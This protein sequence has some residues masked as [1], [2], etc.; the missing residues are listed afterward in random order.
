MKPTASPAASPRL[1]LLALLLAF[2]AGAA[3][4]QSGASGTV[5]IDGESW[6]VADAVAVSDDGD[7]ELWFSKL[8]FDRAEWAED[9]E[10]DTFDTHDFK[11][12]GDGPALRIDVDEEDGRYGGH[13]VRF[14]SSSSSG[15]YSSDLAES[16]TLTTRDD[17]RIAG[18]VKFD[19]G[20]GLAADI[21]FD[22]PLTA[23]GPLAR[24]GT[25]LPKDGGEPGKALKAMVEA[26]HAGNLEKM[27]ALSHPE[28]RAGIEAAKAAGE[29]EEML[30][31]AKLFTPK[32][33]KITGGTSEGDQAWVDFDGQEE[34][35]AVKG[36]AELSRVDG[37][38]Y[39]KR[40]STR[41]G[42]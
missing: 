19:D 16:L 33:T 8:E 27:M 1:R 26:T 15:G 20:S 30:R 14:S 3:A 17:K 2:G 37:Q 12:D 41:S 22:L 10:F 23:T 29:A 5:T 40:I 38:W 7:I 34:G 39:I 35:D 42:D 13:T 18:T 36:S 28:R 31:M 25:P 21:R 4:A 9:G 24:A 6:P 32:I 11:D